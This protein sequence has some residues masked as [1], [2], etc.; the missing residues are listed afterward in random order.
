MSANANSGPV[1]ARASLY[2]SFLHR[3]ILGLPK[4]CIS[5]QTMQ[6]WRF[7]L[8]LRLELSCQCAKWCGADR[9]QEVHAP[10]PFFF[11]VVL[12][13]LCA[14]SSSPEG[15]VPGF[16]TTAA[17]T[18]LTHF[19]VYVRR[20]GAALPCHVSSACFLLCACVFLGSFFQGQ[21][22]NRGQLSNR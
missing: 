19:F 14:A 11:V 2:A 17:F 6:K 3:A 1:D 12:P 22:G 8:F 20:G 10:P 4:T 16:D 21:W 15:V 5:C 18:Q 13:Q 7:V 9:Q